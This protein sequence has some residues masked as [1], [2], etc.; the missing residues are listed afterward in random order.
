MTALRDRFCNP[1]LPNLHVLSLQF[2][3]FYTKTDI[4]K[5]LFNNF[6]NK[7]QESLSRFYSS[8]AAPIG[9]HTADA[10]VEQT[11]FSQDT[12]LQAEMTLSAEEARSIQ[13]RRKFI[14][15]MP[16]WLSAELLEQIETT[17]DENLCFFARIELSIQN[18]CKTDDSVKD[19]FCEII[20]SLRDTLV[21]ALTKLSTIQRT[22]DS[23]LNELSKEF[24]KRN[25]TL[26]NQLEEF[27]KNQA[28]SPQG[29]S[30]SQN[31]GPNSSPSQ[32]NRGKIGG[33]Y[34]V[35]KPGYKRPRTI[36]QPPEWQNQNCKTHRQQSE[37]NYF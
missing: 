13:F 16:I 19:G 25:T 35:N 10:A 28:Q 23:C 9:A 15:N 11:R 29:G 21:S 36:S 6:T 2:L 31:H 8:T 14:Q 30:I 32:E 5:K 37:K 33:R 27:Q 12:L 18:C 34:R 22:T 4:S 26:R 17:T 1:E 3:K 20:R 7:R 24:E